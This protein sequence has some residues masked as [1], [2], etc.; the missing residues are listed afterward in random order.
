MPK[1]TKR[2]KKPQNKTCKKF[3]KKVFLPE[4]ERV[5]KKFS[6]FY[7]TI[8]VLRKKKDN[9]LADILENMYLKS[10]DDIYCQKKC[11]NKKSWVKSFNDKRKTKLMKQGAISGC[12]DLIEEYPNYYKNI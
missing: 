4:R 1:K 6:K 11:K 3:C 5:E 9:V 10:C 7:D 2:I 12:R 8:E